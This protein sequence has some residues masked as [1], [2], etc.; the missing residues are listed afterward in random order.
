MEEDE[1]MREKVLERL[2]E[3]MRQNRNKYEWNKSIYC[4]RCFTFRASSSVMRSHLRDK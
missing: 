4:G 3:R 2:E 1:E